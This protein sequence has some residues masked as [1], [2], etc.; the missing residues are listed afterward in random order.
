MVVSVRTPTWEMPGTCFMYCL[1]WEFLYSTCKD[2]TTPSVNTRVRKRPGVPRADSPLEDELYVV[3]TTQIEVFAND[4]FK[5]DTA[6]QGTIQ[7][8]GQGKLG[9][10]NGHIITVPGG[11]VLCRKGM[12]Q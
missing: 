5:E 6:A 10:E 9:L 2:G 11:P 3:G 4:F 1:M 12:G 8:L 7:N